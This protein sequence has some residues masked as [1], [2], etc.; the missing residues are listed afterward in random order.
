MPPGP[1]IVL[2]VPPERLLFNARFGVAVVAELRAGCRPVRVVLSRDG[3][4]AYVAARASNEIFG[5]DTAKAQRN[6][7]TARLG[8]VTIP[9]PAIGIALS[10]DDSAVFASYDKTLITI[11]TSSINRSSA[12]IENMV[13]VSG[14]GRELSILPDGRTLLLTNYADNL[15]EI[16]DLTRSK[17]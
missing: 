11:N 15:L 6:D 12:A 9:G 16:I 4:R 3:Q 17:K 2:P 5:F 13:A 1:F 7:N 8:S 14:A 10:A